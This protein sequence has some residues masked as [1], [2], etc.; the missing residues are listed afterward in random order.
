[1]K[2]EMFLPRYPR[3]SGRWEV[4]RSAANKRGVWVVRWQLMLACRRMVGAREGQEAESGSGRRGRVRGRHG[5]TDRQQ[6]DRQTAL[7]SG[8]QGRRPPSSIQD[9]DRHAATASGLPVVLR[10]ASRA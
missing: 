1:M 10:A 5:Q 7:G 6:K 9:S 2:L 8:S 4:R 3:R